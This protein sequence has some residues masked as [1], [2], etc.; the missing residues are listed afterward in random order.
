M[1]FPDRNI[2]ILFPEGGFLR[3]RIEGSNRYA[4]RNG[5]A[6]TKYVT[7]PRFGAFRDLID[8]N[9]GVTHIVDAT[10][11]YDDIKDPPSI[12]DIVLGNRKENAVI[13]YRIHKRQD[14]EPTEEWLREIWLDKE[15]L[16]QHYYENRD[17]V[18]KYFGRSIRACKLDWMKLI[19][20]HLFYLVVCY[21]VFRLLS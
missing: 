18:Y 2:L 8:P 15:K 10:L 13:H 21:L 1:Q 5:L 14:I 11:M 17:S 19:A 6:L 4:V 7:H 20:V 3:K 12:L 16:L 9:V